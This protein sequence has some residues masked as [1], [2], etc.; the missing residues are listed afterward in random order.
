MPV[1]IIEVWE[2][3]FTPRVKVKVLFIVWLIR[4][5]FGPRYRFI[6]AKSII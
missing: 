3:K 2:L 6:G 5:V 4:L 1:K